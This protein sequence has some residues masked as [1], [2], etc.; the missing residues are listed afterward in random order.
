M[1]H[2]ARCLQGLHVPCSMVGWGG[3]CF[4]GGKFG[5]HLEQWKEVTG[6]WFF[7]VYIGDEMRPPAMWGL[8]HRIIISYKDPYINAFVTSLLG[9]VELVILFTGSLLWDS[10]HHDSHHHLGG[11]FYPSLQFMVEWCWMFVPNFGKGTEIPISGLSDFQLGDEKGT[12]NHLVFPFSWREP[13]LNLHD[14]PCEEL[15]RIYPPPPSNRQTKGLVRDFQ[16][17]NM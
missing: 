11:S 10:S 8:F 12:L 1:R 3:V 2:R 16:S 13:V 7:W 15:G 5:D 6:P 4:R 14:I 9:C 17:Q